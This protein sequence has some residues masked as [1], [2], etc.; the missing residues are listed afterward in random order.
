MGGLSCAVLTG[1]IS[2]NCRLKADTV[3]GV[4][5]L[6]FWNRDDLIFCKYEHSP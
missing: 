5:F 2:N 6:D 4:Y 3:M 1:Y